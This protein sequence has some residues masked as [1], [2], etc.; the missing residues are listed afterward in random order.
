MKKLQLTLLLL[1]SGAALLA[2]SGDFSIE[3]YRRFL[4]ETRSLSAAGLASRYPAGRF[5]ASVP[6]DW[7][8]ALYADSIDLK[9]L[10]TPGEKQLLQK[11]GFMVS[12]RL[13]YTTFID[14]MADIFHKDLPLFISADA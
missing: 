14:A 10:L 6:L 8:S 4:A 7:R 1:L 13:S 3:S 9:Y 11:N 5:E 12:E 2:Q